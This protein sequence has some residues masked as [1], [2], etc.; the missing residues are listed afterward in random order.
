MR[1]PLFSAL[2]LLSLLL[3]AC[4]SGP[5]S[6][7][8]QDLVLERADTFNYQQQVATSDGREILMISGLSGH[9]AYTVEQVELVRHPDFLQILVHLHA[10]GQPGETGTF[11]ETIAIPKWANR[12]TF[13]EENTVIWQRPAP[14]K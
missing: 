1:P 8:P 12:V 9:S 2:L 7:A 4:Q 14:T 5:S 3:G 6:L 13:G 10:D 11:E